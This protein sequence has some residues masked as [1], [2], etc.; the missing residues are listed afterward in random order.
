MTKEK[1]KNWWDEFW[2]ISFPQLQAKFAEVGKEHQVNE[3]KNKIDQAAK[4]IMSNADKVSANWKLPAAVI[5]GL[6]GGATAHINLED[7]EAIGR[8]IRAIAAPP[9]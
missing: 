8:V 6:P 5:H 4:E 2:E 7:P 1:S 9:D 3:A